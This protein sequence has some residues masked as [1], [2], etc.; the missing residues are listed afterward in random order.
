[1]L[2]VKSLNVPTPNSQLP[3]P[4]S[5]LPTPNSQLPTPN[6]QLPTPN[7][8]LPTPNSQL[9]LNDSLNLILLRRAISH[10]YNHRNHEDNY[11][12]WKFMIQS[13]E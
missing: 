11:R 12:K 5:Q 9:Q 7:S 2:E 10:E 6:S 13:S 3:T 1:M 8:Q 4:N